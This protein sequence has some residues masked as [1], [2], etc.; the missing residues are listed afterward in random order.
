MLLDP[1]GMKRDV[2]R[3]DHRNYTNGLMEIKQ[4]AMNNQWVTE[5]G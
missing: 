2:N 5:K 1:S 3:K 4:Y